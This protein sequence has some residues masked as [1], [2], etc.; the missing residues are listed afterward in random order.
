MEEI[1]PVDLSTLDY[2]AYY[3]YLRAFDWS[4]DDFREAQELQ[5]KLLELMAE[6]SSISTAPLPRKD[7][8]ENL[9]EPFRAY[10]ERRMR[11][12]RDF[13]A[14]WKGSGDRF[15]YLTENSLNMRNRSYSIP[16]AISWAEIEEIFRDLPELPGAISAKAKAKQIEKLEASIAEINARLE[17]VFP[18]RFRGRNGEDMRLCL[19]KSWQ[20]TQSRCNGP[21]GPRGFALAC[22]PDAEKN[23][24]DKLGLREFINKNGLAPCNP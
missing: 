21:C 10:Q 13:F 12:W 3:N 16:P 17:V 2:A 20:E 8:L 7:Q 5:A 18:S 14:E 9:R 19:L 1:Y 6:K 23:A 11:L 15:R 24:W 4:A 22:S